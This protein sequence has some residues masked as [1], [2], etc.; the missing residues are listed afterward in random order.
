[1]SFIQLRIQ[2]I[3]LNLLNAVNPTIKQGV[4][5]GQGRSAD[6]EVNI[7][8]L[9]ILSGLQEG[10]THAFIMQKSQMAYGVCLS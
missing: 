2:R 1:M 4:F 5:C 10:R 7:I 8:A 3:Y 9:F 6:T